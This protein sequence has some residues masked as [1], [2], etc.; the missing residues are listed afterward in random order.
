[1][2]TGQPERY[3]VICFEGA[4]HGRT[5]A[6]LAATGNPKYLKGFGPKVD[7]FDQVPFN[8][9]N[10]VRDAIGPQTAGIIVEPLQGEGG[11][12]RAGTAISARSARRLRR[13]RPG[14]RPRRGPVRHGAHR[15]AVRL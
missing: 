12:R 13:V 10:A 2:N 6:M 11:I 7:G 8:N 15:Q 1:M 5:L 4:F 3:R 14:A 9:L